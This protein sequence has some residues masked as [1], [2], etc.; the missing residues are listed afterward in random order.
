MYAVDVD[1]CM[2][3]ICTFLFRQFLTHGHMV[4]S[5]F[6]HAQIFMHIDIRLF[7]HGTCIISDHG[8]QL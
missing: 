5:E 8:E 4:N 6:Q 3:Y 2:F 1:I 7:I